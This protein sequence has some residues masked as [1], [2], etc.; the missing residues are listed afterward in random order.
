MQTVCWLDIARFPFA[1]PLSGSVGYVLCS[2]FL[3]GC[4]VWGSGYPWALEWGAQTG[5]ILSQ[6]LRLGPHLL[7][8]LCPGLPV[9]VQVMQV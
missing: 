6:V 7:P 3:V 4:V 8:V 2:F 9:V 5:S 1:L